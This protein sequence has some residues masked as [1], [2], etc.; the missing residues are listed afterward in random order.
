M[1]CLYKLRGTI[2]VIADELAAEILCDWALVSASEAVEQIRFEFAQKGRKCETM[3]A[4][5]CAGSG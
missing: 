3:A 2:G 5:Q 1:C 4:P